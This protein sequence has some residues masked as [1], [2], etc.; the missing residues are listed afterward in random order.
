[1]VE[2]RTLMFVIISS[3][4]FR[5]CIS[6]TGLKVVKCQFSCSASI[7]SNHKLV[8]LMI[9]RQFQLVPHTVLHSSEVCVFVELNFKIVKQIS[10]I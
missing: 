7:G 2:I 6:K 1:M 10:I 9:R 5:D 8:T 4:D 3:L